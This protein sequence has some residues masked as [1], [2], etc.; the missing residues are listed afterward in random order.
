MPEYLIHFSGWKRRWDRCVAEELILPNSP[1]NKKL[2]K[3]L[4][5]EAAQKLLQTSRSRKPKVPAILKESLDRK[6]RGSSRKERS[7]SGSSSRGEES[8]SSQ[9]ES[10]E[11]QGDFSDEEDS[12]DEPQEVATD[13]NINIPQ[14]LRT[15]L[16]DD[17]YNITSKK[18]LVHVP[19]TPDVV[20]I[21]EAF[22]KQYAAKLTGTA[23]RPAKGSS[24]RQPPIDTSEIEAR[25]A[26]CKEA[27]D[28]LRIIFSYTLSNQLLYN[29]EQS[30]FKL[31]TASCRPIR[32]S[33]PAPNRQ[34]NEPTS[35]NEASLLN[36]APDVATTVKCRS[37]KSLRGNS[38]PKGSTSSPQRSASPPEKRT[39]RSGDPHSIWSS[40]PA[41][42]TQDDSDTDNLPLAVAIM[43]RAPRR[44]TA[45]TCS[46]ASSVSAITTTSEA[47]LSV[48][49]SKFDCTILPSEFL[50]DDP[51]SP[52][53]LYGAHH[54]LRLFVKLPVL[55]QKMAITKRKASY[56][57]N[58]VNGLL[59]YLAG[60]HEE[61]F[62]PTAYG[63][64]EQIMAE[65]EKQKTSNE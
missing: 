44:R 22:L 55:L 27:M 21:L 19:C 48:V 18:K 2:K 34:S 4:E 52:A 60:R 23:A 28:G 3:K 42:S 46:V 25:F 29:L 59:Q 14:I 39:V 50:D 30:Q 15:K 45:S 65:L 7:R 32:I 49:N 17:F 5:A 54:F 51:S 37:R 47:A 8:D 9:S 24:L 43:G 64:A 41:K 12:D 6:L 20:D 10:S 53:L 36:I 56:L 26:L 57:E 38:D 16:E 58:F 61:L 11:K 63:D 40:S 13:Y 31:V 62:P 35:Q 33:N 1:E